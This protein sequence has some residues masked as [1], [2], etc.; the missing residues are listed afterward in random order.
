[1]RT[2][3]ED[4]IKLHEAGAD[5]SG[6]TKQNTPWPNIVLPLWGLLWGCYFK[7]LVVAFEMLGNTA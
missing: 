1:L 5:V 7:L 3:H 2:I 4:P 6:M